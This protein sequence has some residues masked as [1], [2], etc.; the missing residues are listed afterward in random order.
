MVGSEIYF[1][2]MYSTLIIVHLDVRRDGKSGV[3][4][5]QRFWPEEVSAQLCHLLKWEP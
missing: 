2:E 4:E 3:W 5:T 1:I